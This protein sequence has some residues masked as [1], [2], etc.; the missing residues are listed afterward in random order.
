M[1]VPTSIASYYTGHTLYRH[2]L[3]I[4]YIPT[5]V[6]QVIQHSIH[7]IC[8]GKFYIIT[9][10]RNRT[11]TTYLN[12]FNSRLVYTSNTASKLL[13]PKNNDNTNVTN[14][15]QQLSRIF[16]NFSRY[17]PANIY[18]M[19][20]DDADRRIHIKNQLVFVK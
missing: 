8:M 16:R 1:Y 20:P 4:Y 11:A 9:C 2:R 5:H 12:I 6:K 15:T 7:F 17:Q 14:V 10:E 3:Q 18:I 19:T 13:T